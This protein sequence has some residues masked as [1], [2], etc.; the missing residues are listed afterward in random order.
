MPRVSDAHVTA[1]RLQI[2][3][4]ARDCF[5]R[6]GFHRT[7]MADVFEASGLSA[8]AVYHY[9]RSKDELI[10]A[11]VSEAGGGLRALTE[12]ILSADPLP[13][14][15]D[16]LLALLEFVDAQARDGGRLRIALQ[17]WSEAA[18]D[19]TLRAQVAEAYS[20]LREALVELARRNQR[21]GRLD[22]QADAE[23]LGRLLFG[24]VPGY[25]VQRLVV[26]PEGTFVP[27]DF[28]DDLRPLLSLVTAPREA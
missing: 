18:R 16:G 20:G 15:A 17:V 7:S 13:D 19:E 25:I 10:A 9:F 24:L 6:D 22:P 4:A 3:D 27:A 26:Y 1:R 8:G 11:I 5:S 23:A 12:T 2:L 21:Q 14:L 28:L